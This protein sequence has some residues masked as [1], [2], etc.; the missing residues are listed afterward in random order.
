MRFFS[1]INLTNWKIWKMRVWEINQTKILQNIVL[2]FWL[3]YDQ[4]LLSQY[5]RWMGVKGRWHWPR[6]PTLTST[7]TPFPAISRSPRNWI[8]TKTTT[9]TRWCPTSSY[10]SCVFRPGQQE[11]WDIVTWK[12]RNIYLKGENYLSERWEI[13]TWKVRTIFMK[14]V[15]YLRDKSD[16][17]ASI[18]WEC[19]VIYIFIFFNKKI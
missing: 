4:G 3:L 9:E 1:V 10:R 17:S 13:Y 19:N 6:P 7:L 2:I 18:S 14:G 12:V 8:R 15:L 16:F 11:R 5:C